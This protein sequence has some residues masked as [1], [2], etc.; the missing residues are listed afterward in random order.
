MSISPIETRYRG[1]RFRS[2]LEA[3]WAVFFDRCG[4]QYDYERQGFDLGDGIRH[5][6]DF[7]L[8]DQS[9]RLHGTQGMW[10]EVRP[11]ELRDERIQ[12]ACSRLATATNQRVALIDFYADHLPWSGGLLYYPKIG[13]ATY[14]ASWY[15]C[16]ECRALH[17]CE[18]PW[19]R[20]LWCPCGF[21]SDPG[22]EGP[23]WVA[24]AQ[25]VAAYDAARGARFEHGE[26]PP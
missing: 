24:D 2:R 13:Q 21:N 18:P 15:R 23:D 12:E 6:P 10:A 7:Y 4:I 16:P 19:L 26:S 22:D 20:C 1:Y 5:L 9:E 11:R 14:S 3:R 17:L 8:P 25:M